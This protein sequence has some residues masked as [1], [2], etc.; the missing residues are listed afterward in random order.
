MEHDELTRLLATLPDGEW[1]VRPSEYADGRSVVSV[2]ENA[3]TVIATDMTPEAASFLARA[4]QVL[5]ELLAAFEEERAYY[6]GLEAENERLH[7]QAYELTQQLAASE[8]ELFH[9]SASAR[10]DA[11]PVPSPLEAPNTPRMTLWHATVSL[12]A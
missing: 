1:L 3:A 11:R 6:A 4:R 10:D 7:Q 8:L 9:L 5:P 12:S 2:S